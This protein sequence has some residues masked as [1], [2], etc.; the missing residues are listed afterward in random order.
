M[1]ENSLTRR[2]V[3]CIDGVGDISDT[4]G[5][6]NPSSIARLHASINT[7][8]FNDEKGRTVKQVVKYYQVIT[9]ESTALGKSG[10]QS[11][12]S[13]EQQIHDIVF[14]ICEQL[15]TPKDEIFLFG[16]GRGAYAVRA[17]AGIL[18]HMGVPDADQLKDFTELYTSTL[19][20]IKACETE[21]NSK[22]DTAAQ[23]L[24]T[25]NRN[26]ANIRFVGLL[27]AVKNCEQKEVYNTRIVSTIQNFRHAMAFNENRRTNSLD[28]PEAPNE[29]D[30]VG[31]SF[32]Q[33]WFLGYHTDLVGGVQY[34]GLSIYPLQW[35]MIEAMLTGLFLSFNVTGKEPVPQENPL[36]LT[37][38][39]Y[40][41]IAPNL[42]GCD[43]NL[44]HIQYANNVEIRMFDLQSIHISEQKTQKASHT[45]HFENINPLYNEPRQIFKEGKE[46][47][48]GYEAGHP[49]GTIIH[50]SVF[51]IL[52]RNQCFLE[53]NR[54]KVYR[55]NLAD[56]ETDCLSSD[57]ANMLPWH[58]NSELLQ[59]GVKAF[60]IL[61][62]G[63][64]GV[65][66]STLIN[67]VF[68]VTMVRIIPL[69]AWYYKLL[70]LI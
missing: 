14:D 49:Y 36:A 67:K 16:S 51:C 27:D 19:N 55:E 47:L 43:E 58:Q 28:M 59:S 26:T 48:I 44:W 50:P 35:I 18:H 17:I 56:F 5:V 11:T 13:T 15:E 37:F 57:S 1:S 39:Q 10:G 6:R 2:C 31:R 69:R 9:S 52:D 29:N 34:D 25:V 3:V 70:T 24:R 30:L 46:G 60:R 63:K 53:H 22:D 64:T 12:T 61:V 4:P 54:F 42:G 68:G 8:L 62:C 21:D 66:K 45:L 20:L 65:G 38:P 23:G 7:G 40:A 33:A 41:G 32:L